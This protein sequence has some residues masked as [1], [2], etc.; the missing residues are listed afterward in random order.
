MMPVNG[1]KRRK[2]SIWDK[3][4]DRLIIGK[5]NKNTVTF[6]LFF[7]TNLELCFG[8]LGEYN[9]QRECITSQL[10]L[11]HFIDKIHAPE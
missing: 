10:V 2:R 4:V 5:Y 9:K 6:A 8:Q 7:F 1:K 11:R 3:K